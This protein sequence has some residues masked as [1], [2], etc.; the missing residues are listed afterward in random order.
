MPKSGENKYFELKKFAA[1]VRELTENLPTEAE[2]STLRVQIDAILA[3]LSQM[4]KS[5]E[6]LPSIEE[7]DGARKAVNVLDDLAVRAKSNPILAAALGLRP[8]QR[9]RARSALLTQEES[10]NA[11]SLLE[12]LRSMSID[13]MNLRLGTEERTP[14]RE[15][16]AVASLLGIRPTQRVGRDGLIRQ[17]VTKISN[18]RGY[19]EL[20]GNRNP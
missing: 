10:K 17:I 14:T 11:E 18:F 7:V 20:Q 2:K 4:Q 16:E 9:S 12:Q 5:I 19:Q 13:E 3:F 8:P 15:L 6:T 1:N